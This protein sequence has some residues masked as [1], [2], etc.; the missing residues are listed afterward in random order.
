M[1]SSSMPINKLDSNLNLSVKH[2]WGRIQKEKTDL[3]LTRPNKGSKV[4]SSCNIKE[5]EN[6]EANR[7]KILK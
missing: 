3:F 2:N 7:E 4:F 6:F 5:R 1:I